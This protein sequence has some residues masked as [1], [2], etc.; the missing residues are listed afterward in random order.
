MKLLKEHRI[1]L[2]AFLLSAL[3]LTFCSQASFVFPCHGRVDQNC[4]L[5]VGKGI[6][7]GLVPYRDL[8][9][10]KGPL[11]YFLHAL[12]WLITPDSFTGVYLL[13][14][15][16]LTVALLYVH[17]ISNLYLPARASILI[18]PATALLIT[19]SN[20]F[21][22]GDNAE[23][24]CIPLLLASLYSILRFYHTVSGTSFRSCQHAAM[25]ASSFLIHGILAGCVL[26][27]KFTMLGFWAAWAVLALLPDLLAKRVK[28]LFTNC[29]LFLGGMA[30]ATIPWVVYFGL[31]GAISDWLYA[32]LY[33]N[34]FLY[35]KSLSPLGRVWHLAG[36]IGLAAVW[37]PL[38][39]G[40]IAMGILWFRPPLAQALERK[41][42]LITLIAVTV[43]LYI[44]GT[45]YDYYFLIVSPFALFGVIGAVYRYSA[46][47][48]AYKFRYGRQAYCILCL[49]TLTLAIVLSNCLPY[50][51]MKKEDYPQYQFAEIITHKPD[52]T[53]LNY[54][55]L[56]G[57]FYKAAG[58]DPLTKYFCRLNI[59]ADKLPEMEE[60]HRRLLREGIPDFVV[61][62]SRYTD[63]WE[64][65][66]CP[67]LF[68]NYVVIAE[69]ENLPD[70]Y[71]YYLF[72][73]KELPSQ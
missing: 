38:L 31:H 44:G 13:E 65:S 11:L 32:Y 68:Q 40:A 52:S 35:S 66:G 16:F 56:D 49:L 17:K 5:T 47:I 57:G 71:K 33:S 20:C 15:V 25:P 14:I 28:S 58:K 37:N 42:M 9:E 55:F 39:A 48:A 26:W 36:S 59:P 63:S 19:T 43:P 8:F 41:V 70:F 54:G 50:Y 51:G 23:E 69:G 24:F 22:R 60:S 12:A 1:L 73:R 4:F 62:R 3:L 46:R 27:I 7:E 10:Q 18:L 45:N 34:I 29:L 2:Y 67:E 6:V 61:T 53:M 21:L 30:V 72:Q 64:D